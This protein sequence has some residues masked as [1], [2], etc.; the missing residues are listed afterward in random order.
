MPFPYEFPYYFGGDPTDGVDV[1]PPPGATDFVDPFVPAL[2]W[3]NHIESARNKLL[4]QFRDKPAI[5]ALLDSWTAKIQEVE[6]VFWALKLLTGLYTSEGKQLEKIGQIVGEPDRNGQTD[7]DYRLRILARITVNLSNG[8]REDLLL[9]L[10]MIL[11]DT[12]PVKVEE[13]Y[14]A[15]M[16]YTLLGLTEWAPLIY[17]FLSRAKMGGVRLFL[18]HSEAP[19]ESVFTMDSEYASV[20]TSG[21]WMGSVYD[22]TIG[23]VMASVLG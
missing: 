10:S 2:A 9:V 17:R 12:F 4:Y 19:S 3:V 1:P 21:Q 15:A 18:V 5:T 23:G 13:H 6:N 22:A 20:T 14:P 8:R 7:A 11:G 16:T